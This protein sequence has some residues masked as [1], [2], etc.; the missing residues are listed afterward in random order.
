M[1]S[2]NDSISFWAAE[3]RALETTDPEGAAEDEGEGEGGEG[4]EGEDA[5]PNRELDTCETKG[6]RTDGASEL[7]CKLG[8]EPPFVI[9]R[10]DSALALE[11]IS[12][13]LCE[14]EGKENMP[15]IVPDNFFLPPPLAEDGEEEGDE[16]P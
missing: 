3:Y 1:V 13:L 15:V 14:R 5:H 7:D 4:E 10:G 12:L 9:P 6:G 2:C 11:A 16:P 8:I